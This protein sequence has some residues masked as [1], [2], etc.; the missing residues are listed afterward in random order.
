MFDIELLVHAPLPRGDFRSYL[1]LFYKYTLKRSDVRVSEFG[2][3][4]ILR[5]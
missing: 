2:C 3:V 5:V 4:T 1:L